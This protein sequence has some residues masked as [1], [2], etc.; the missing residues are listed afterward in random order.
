MKSYTIYS[1]SKNDFDLRIELNPNSWALPFSFHKWYK[2][3]EIRIF[4]LSIEIDWIP[5]PF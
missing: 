1:V 3:L 5:L 4:C 2:V